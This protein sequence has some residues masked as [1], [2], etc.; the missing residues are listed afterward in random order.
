MGKLKRP[1]INI[2]QTREPPATIELYRKIKTSNKLLT[3][4]F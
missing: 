3:I 2:K 4:K 1:N